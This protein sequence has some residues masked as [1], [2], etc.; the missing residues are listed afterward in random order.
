MPSP[1][2]VFSNGPMQPKLWIFATKPSVMVDFVP[3]VGDIV[4][5]QG[6]G[7]YWVDDFRT[8]R[9]DGQV[10]PVSVAL[11]AT[12]VSQI[13]YVASSSGNYNL[14]AVSVVYG[15]A[16]TVAATVQ[17]EVSG[18]GVAQG[19]G[20]NQL[21]GTIALNSTINT[22]LNGT[23]IAAPTL[24]VPGSKVSLIIPTAPTTLANC[25]VTLYLIPA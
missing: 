6:G 13:V 1:I 5:V 10:L 19:S 25:I 23:V 14:S 9:S 20:T 17:V 2:K 15:T 21:T 18:A 8:L 12:S 7:T 3:Q 24:I 4:F 11:V 16:S 22:V